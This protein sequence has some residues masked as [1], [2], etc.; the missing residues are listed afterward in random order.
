ML[1]VLVV[2]TFHHM[3]LGLQVVPYDGKSGERSQSL[4]IADHVCA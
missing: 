3:H 2:M 1:L 4:N